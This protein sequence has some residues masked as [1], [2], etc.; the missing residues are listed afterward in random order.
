[1]SIIV[2]SDTLGLQLDMDL[3][4]DPVEVEIECNYSGVNLYFCITLYCAVSYFVVTSTCVAGERFDN[5]LKLSNYEGSEDHEDGI[6]T[7]PATP[8][9]Q[10]KAPEKPQILGSVPKIYPNKTKPRRLL[11][12]DLNI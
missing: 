6:G 4:T 10:H 12:V 5:M 2:D 11:I 3:E 1:M 9:S 8:E 7:L